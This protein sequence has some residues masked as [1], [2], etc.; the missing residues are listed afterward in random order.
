MYA[1]VCHLQSF[2]SFTWVRVWGKILNSG[3]AVILVSV[4][5]MYLHNNLAYG[6]VALGR[7]LVRN[8]TMKYVN[9]YINLFVLIKI[10]LIIS[11]INIY[12]FSVGPLI[13][14]IH[15]TRIYSLWPFRILF[16]INIQHM[17]II[18]LINISLAYIYI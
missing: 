8:K 12:T 3:F 5:S 11:M 17:H 6:V 2:R 9:S 18:S 14:N 1:S 13:T 10:S 7:N 16:F 15:I 4:T